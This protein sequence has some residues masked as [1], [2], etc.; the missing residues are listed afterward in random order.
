MLPLSVNTS[1][2]FGIKLK[3]EPTTDVLAIVDAL[4]AVSPKPM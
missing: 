4:L 2:E 3:V 1:T